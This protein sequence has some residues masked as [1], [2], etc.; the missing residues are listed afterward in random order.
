MRL[1]FR[2]GEAFFTGG[3]AGG[4]GLLTRAPLQAEYLLGILNSRLLDWMHQQRATQMRGGWY[5]YESRFIAPLPIHPI[6]FSNKADKT[7]YDRMVAMVQAMLDLHKRRAETRT[8]DDQTRLDRDIAA[9]DKQIDALVYDLYGLTDEEIR[10][11][12]GGSA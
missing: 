12:E 11:V 5:S 1:S 8:P 3:A 2:S 4:Y 9:L 7:K 6:D 10:I